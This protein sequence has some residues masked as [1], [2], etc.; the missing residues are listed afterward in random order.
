MQ[1]K[2]TQ[3]RFDA[4]IISAE[5][6]TAGMAPQNQIWAT[7]A[8]KG[9][10][11]MDHD[12]LIHRKTSCE[13]GGRRSSHYPLQDPDIGEWVQNCMGRDREKKADGYP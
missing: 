8:K 9:F 5:L 6:E 10:C 12:G 3:R 11:T 1:P 13:Q 7:I 4:G 2:N